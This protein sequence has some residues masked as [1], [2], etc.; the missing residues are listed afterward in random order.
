MNG[1]ETFTVHQDQKGNK[2]IIKDGKVAKLN[3][4]IPKYL[5]VVK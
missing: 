5:K 1:I 4:P 2:F 3:K